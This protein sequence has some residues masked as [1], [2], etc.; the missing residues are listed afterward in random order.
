MNQRPVSAGRSKA[1]SVAFWVTL[2]QGRA[3]A[4][5]QFK[6]FSVVYVDVGFC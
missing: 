2:K 5:D 1:L 3:A 4:V 6:T